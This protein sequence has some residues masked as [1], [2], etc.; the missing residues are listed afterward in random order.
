MQQPS[1]T[2][3]QL[4][5]TL[6][7]FPAFRD[8]EEADLK[9]LCADATVLEFIPGQVVFEQGDP[10]S[11]ALL[12][13][14]GRLVAKVEGGPEEA[15]VGECRPG[16][17]V[18]ESALLGRENHRNAT[19]FSALHTTCMVVSPDLL[20]IE[21]PQAAMALE[22]YLIATITRRIRKTN[23]AI[24]LFW[25]DNPLDV[26][27]HEEGEAPVTLKSRLRALFSGFSR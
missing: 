25:K 3:D 23:Q 5:A 4:I 26:I 2:P 11:S 24:K 6:W 22:Q 27:I 1:M 20:A 18:G 8:L 15:R 9:A 7:S 21:N 14:R 16:E 17:L 12:V 10:A 19:V 13:L